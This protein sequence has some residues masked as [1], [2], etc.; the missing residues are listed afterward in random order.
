MFEDRTS[1]L[2]VRPPEFMTPP[3]LLGLLP[4]LIIRPEMVTPVA[5]ALTAK[6]GNR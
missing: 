6:T 5:P 1:L 2:S 4:S 3:P